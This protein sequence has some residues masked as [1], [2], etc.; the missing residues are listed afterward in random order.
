MH[1]YISLKKQ[2]KKTMEIAPL[3]ILFLI[4]FF[5]SGFLKYTAID[6]NLKKKEVQLNPV[7]TECNNHLL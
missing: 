2:K 6:Q 7:N 4:S 3:K 5:V 1:K